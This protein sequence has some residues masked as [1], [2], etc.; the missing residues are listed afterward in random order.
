MTSI[1]EGAFSGC[2][3]L[4]EISVAEDNTVYTSE[5]GVLFDKA[6]TALLTYPAGKPKAE[7]VIPDSVTRIG[8]YAFSTW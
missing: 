1:G 6:K 3:S 2:S 8:T 7:Y 4:T 5:N